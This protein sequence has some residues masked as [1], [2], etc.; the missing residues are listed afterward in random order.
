MK[1]KRRNLRMRLLVLLLIVIMLCTEQMIVLAEVMDG[2][3]FV[4][5]ENIGSDSYVID[6]SLGEWHS[7]AIMENGDLYCWG[8]NKYGQVGNGTKIDQTTPARVLSG[9]ESVFLSNT[10]SAAIT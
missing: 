4:K 2:D 6:A 3:D 9:V 7:A 8:W 10:S 5:E 1:R